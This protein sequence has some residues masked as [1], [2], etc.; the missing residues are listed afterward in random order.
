MSENISHLRNILFP[1]LHPS[2]IATT[3]ALQRIT[4]SIITE[5]KSKVPARGDKVDSG[6]GL[7]RVKVL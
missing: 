7:P 2:C 3:Y 6:I 4:K 1:A 5:A